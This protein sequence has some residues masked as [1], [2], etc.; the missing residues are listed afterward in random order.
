MFDNF[1][2]LSWDSQ[3]QHIADSVRD[4]KG[5]V[6][7]QL[8][9]SKHV[10]KKMFLKTYGITCERARLA[11]RE[12]L[13]LPALRENLVLPDQSG[14]EFPANKTQYDVTWLTI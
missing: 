12:N 4:K 8:A 13:V 6:I 9:N 5:Q 7:Y 3:E 11:V 2:K 14:Q 10:C 1:W